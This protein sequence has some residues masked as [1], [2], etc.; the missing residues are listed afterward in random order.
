MHARYYIEKV[1]D[2]D[3]QRISVKIGFSLYVISLIVYSFSLGCVTSER[4]LKLN[5]MHIKCRHVKPKCRIMRPC[6]AGRQAARAATTGWLRPVHSNFMLAPLD[7]GDLPQP[8]APHLQPY[9]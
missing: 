9:A 7:L 1:K 6:K 8:L 5:L 2:G 3:M 4:T